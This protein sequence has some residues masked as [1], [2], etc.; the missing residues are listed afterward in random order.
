MNSRPF[1]QG[2]MSVRGQPPWFGRWPRDDGPECFEEGICRLDDPVSSSA[3]QADRTRVPWNQSPAPDTECQVSRVRTVRMTAAAAPGLWRN[4]QVPPHPVLPPPGGAGGASL[5]L[6]PQP[7]VLLAVRRDSESLEVTFLSPAPSHGIGSLPNP[8]QLVH[9]VSHSPLHLPGLISQV[10]GHPLTFCCLHLHTPPS[11]TSLP[12]HHLVQPL[13][14]GPRLR[15]LPHAR[16]PASLPRMGKR[17]TQFPL[18]HAG[19]EK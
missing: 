8:E 9:R 3:W 16:S 19:E 15:R 12:T 17:V 4:W 14:N 5:R 10:P 11:P 6:S 2:H 18:A 1:L 7:P 13:S